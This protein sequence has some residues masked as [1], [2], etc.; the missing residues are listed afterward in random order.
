MRELIYTVL[1][2]EKEYKNRNCEF[3]SNRRVNA[4]KA[5]REIVTRNKATDKL[6]A[7]DMICEECEE[8]YRNNQILKCDRCGRLQT[9]LDFDFFSGKNVCHC[10][11]NNEDLERKE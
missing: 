3:C 7:V 8:K 2:L 5:V 10:V 4:N 6:I 1:E 11:R 9:K